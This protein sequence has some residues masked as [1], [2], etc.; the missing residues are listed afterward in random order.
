MKPEYRESGK[1][2]RRGVHSQTASDIRLYRVQDRTHEQC[3]GTASRDGEV[4]LGQIDDLVGIRGQARPPCDGLRF[5]SCAAV[6]PLALLDGVY[7][8]LVHASAK[9]AL[10]RRE[11]ERGVNLE[12]T[13]LVRVVR[14]VYVISLILH[15]DFQRLV[16]RIR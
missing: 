10:S 3:T 8:L 5:D 16:L 9:C 13:E 7:P 15:R 6:W 14:I 11:R 12:P 4:N 2:E 1:T